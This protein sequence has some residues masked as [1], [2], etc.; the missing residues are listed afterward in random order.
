MLQSTKIHLVLV[1]PA[2][3]LLILQ[4]LTCAKSSMTESTKFT[5]NTP[6]RQGAKKVTCI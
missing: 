2:Y 4:Y 3:R 1:H 6:E 5:K